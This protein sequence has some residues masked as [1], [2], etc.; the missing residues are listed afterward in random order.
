MIGSFGSARMGGR[1]V[2][3]FTKVLGASIYDLLLTGLKRSV[4]SRSTF[5][6]LMT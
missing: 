6:L 2:R 4:A 1:F 5:T 3:R